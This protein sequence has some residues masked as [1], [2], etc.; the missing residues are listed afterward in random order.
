MSEGWYMTIEKCII[1]LA[2]ESDLCD[3]LIS[4]ELLVLS[5][6]IN[7][8]GLRVSDIH[9]VLGG[10]KSWVSNLCLRLKGAG[11]ATLTKE[12]REVYYNL[13]EKGE[14][15]AKPAFNLIHSLVKAEKIP[16][17]LSDNTF[18]LYKTPN[19]DENDVIKKIRYPIHTHKGALLLNQTEKNL[20]F[21]GK[22]S[23]NKLL[24]LDIPIK[25]IET[26]EESFNSY[27]KWRN[28]PLPTPLILKYREAEGFQTIY[29]FTEYRIM[30]RITQNTEWV[31]L[32]KKE[33][34]LLEMKAENS[35]SLSSN[36][37]E[38]IVE[39]T[40]EL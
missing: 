26:F 3:D 21:I 10:N 31:K 24:M 29:L 15:V 9:A 8:S 37:T 4:K 2:M 38:T 1:R 27:Y 20:L 33:K 35:E 11:L 12:G 16:Y 30:G 22:N 28:R 7:E 17:F 32:L 34:N 39:S 19:L 18:I 25:N 23:K 5:S 6:L 14:S 40:G 36:D 13:T